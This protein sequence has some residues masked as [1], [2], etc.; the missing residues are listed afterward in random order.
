MNIQSRSLLA[1]HFFSKLAV[2]C[3][4]ISWRFLPLS[5]S[6]FEGYHL[7][8]FLCLK[9]LVCSSPHLFFFPNFKR[10]KRSDLSSPFWFLPEGNATVVL[11]TLKNSVFSSGFVWFC[12]TKT[13]SIG[14][15]SNRRQTDK[16]VF[17]KETNANGQR[18]DIVRKCKNFQ[19]AK[20]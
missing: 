18:K 1:I 17:R 9:F 5:L 15:E 13:D 11:T 7:P 12:T 8:P 4:P 10:C 16:S 20:F 3:T 14:Q 2:K 6:L 19:R